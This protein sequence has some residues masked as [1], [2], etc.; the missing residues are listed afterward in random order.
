MPHSRCRRGVAQLAIQARLPLAWTSCM[1]SAADLGQQRA[2]PAIQHCRLGAHS[3][4]PLAPVRLQAC[5][6]ETL[7]HCFS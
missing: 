4:T 2:Q 7:V 1:H 6:V 3:P 5:L